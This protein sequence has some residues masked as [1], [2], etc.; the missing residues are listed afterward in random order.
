[1]PGAIALWSFLF[2]AT[3]FSFFSPSFLGFRLTSADAQEPDNTA[4]TGRGEGGG[5]GGV[6][7]PGLITPWE[8]RVAGCG[9]DLEG[10][11]RARVAV[12]TLV[13]TG[14]KT[15]FRCAVINCAA[16]LLAGGKESKHKK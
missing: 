3:F 12:I 4:G 8:L 11:I 15:I 10:G 14:Q 5:G 13:S 2:V 6:Y 1:M 16:L 9:A 7:G